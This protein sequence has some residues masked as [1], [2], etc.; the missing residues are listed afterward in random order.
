MAV[1]ALRAGLGGVP[2]VTLVVAF[3]GEDAGAPARV[4]LLE[5]LAVVLLPGA[6]AGL[7]GLGDTVT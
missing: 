1:V 7:T 2:V 6:P 4:L 5:G 3:M